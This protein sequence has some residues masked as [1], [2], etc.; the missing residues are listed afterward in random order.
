MLRFFYRNRFSCSKL[1]V[2]TSHR[3][4]T[5]AHQLPTVSPDRN[6]NVVPEFLLTYW[7][8]VSVLEIR[9]ICLHV[10]RQTKAKGPLKMDPAGIG[11][12]K[13]DTWAKLLTV[14]HSW[15]QKKIGVLYEF[16]AYSF[17]SSTSKSCRKEWPPVGSWSEWSAKSVSW[18][19]A[20]IKGQHIATCFECFKRHISTL[21]IIVPRS[22]TPTFVAQPC[23]H[24]PVA[25]SLYQRNIWFLAHLAHAMPEIIQKELISGS[26]SCHF[27][28]HFTGHFTCHFTLLDCIHF[29]SLRTVCECLPMRG[30]EAALVPR[31]VCLDT[32]PQIQCADSRGFEIPLNKGQNNTIHE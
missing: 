4:T 24:P 11:C 12:F 18:L 14:D 26:L 22:L 5:L 25:E 20:S 7:V 9:S 30:G 10:L 23:K 21:S 6:S 1:G 16:S 15:Q 31:P 8:P 17:V 27:T 2:K 32:S 28:G 19:L 29:G 13:Y 3:P